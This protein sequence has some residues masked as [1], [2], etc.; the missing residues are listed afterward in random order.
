[1]VTP[2]LTQRMVIIISMIVVCMSMVV[3]SRAQAAPIPSVWS[4]TLDTSAARQPGTLQFVVTFSENVTGVDTSDFSLSGDVGTAVIT[5]VTPHNTTSYVVE[6]TNTH[7][8]RGLMLAVLDDDSI[9]NSAGMPLGGDGASNGSF[10]S[11]AVVG[12]SPIQSTA[13]TS[14]PLPVVQPVSNGLA[15]GWYPSLALTTTNLPVMSYYDKTKEDLRLAICDSLACTNPT[16]RILQSTF[17]VGEYTSLALTSTNN[18]VISFFN[19]FTNDLW[20]AICSN[21][22]CTTHVLR[23][24]DNSTGTN[25]WYTSLA[26][27]KTNIPVISYV[28]NTTNTLKLA[29][30]N[31]PLCTAPVIRT[32]E[33]T[34]GLVTGATSL[35][36]TSTNVPIIGFNLS[37]GTP[38]V[39]TNLSL[40][41][42]SNPTCTSL[43]ISTIADV[44]SSLNGQDNDVALTSTDIPIIS[45]HDNNTNDIKLAVCDTLS[46][47]S[48]TVRDIDT[49]GSVGKASSIKLTPNNIPVI[50][51]FDFTNQDLKLAICNNTDCTAPRLETLDS[52]GY[53]GSFT[54]L[55]LMPST[56]PLS[57][58][59]II[60]YYDITNQS[61]KLYAGNHQ[62]KLDTVVDKGLPLAFAKSLPA[63][64][65]LNQP[66]N[67]TLKWVPSSYAPDYE[68]CY[69]TS[70]E[71]C[72]TWS[73]TTLTQ[74]TLSGLTKNTAYYW[75]VRARNDAGTI[76]STGGYWKFTTVK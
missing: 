12:M 20:L 60:S 7:D 30:C 5:Q 22:T 27:T 4:V 62:L 18:P 68:Y 37:Y 52:T 8:S 46:C 42:C 35:A 31:N 58:T 32:F 63:N 34:S 67:V 75:Q 47:T 16:I 61:L 53:V 76:V 72:T 65:A 33:A 6:I 56:H 57:I 29:I 43:T 19:A 23:Q 25:G 9:R 15:V 21:P 64:N 28:N 71:A 40:G 55:A 73:T 38:L 41:I 13:P 14:T 36:L 66:V 24:V 59:P 54:S 48:P 51:Y 11:T 1:M 10:V 26:L 3:I 74:V 49:S 50:S 69:A 17:I 2:L 70:I 44:A 45:F 39:G